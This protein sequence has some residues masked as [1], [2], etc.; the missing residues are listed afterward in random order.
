MKSLVEPDE[1]K[2]RMLTLAALD[3]IF[4]EE[5]WLRYYNFDSQW[6]PNVS[7]ATID[8]GSGD[9]LFILF[10]SEGVIMKGFDHESGLSPYAREEDEVFP[11]IYDQTPASLLALL[12]D[13][14]FEKEDVTFCIWREIN[15]TTWRKGDVQIPKDEEDGSEFLLS[16]IVKTPEDYV[17]WAQDYY[18]IPISIEVIKKIYDGSTIEEAVIQSLNPSRN[19]QDALRELDI[20]V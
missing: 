17:E 14:A 5:D 19:A 3:I 13:E 7:L 11:S 8:N 4:C 9:N 16:M 15:D 2:K 10:A 1:L 18:D 20:L 6:A 12:D